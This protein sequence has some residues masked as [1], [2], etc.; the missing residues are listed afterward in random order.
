MA[1]GAIVGTS[2][3]QQSV[4]AGQG[5]IDFR[6]IVAA[7]GTIGYDD[8]VAVEILPLPSADEAAAEAIRFLRSLIPR[9]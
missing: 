2:T 6:A 8:D 3:G 9:S 7:L 1:A 4:G 5:H